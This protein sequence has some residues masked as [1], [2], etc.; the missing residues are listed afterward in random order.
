VKE[1]DKYLVLK[2][3]GRVAVAM[4]GGVDSSTAAAILKNDG[5][6]VI[7]LTMHLWDQKLDDP[8]EMGRCCSPEDIRDARR[9]ADQIGIPHY[10]INLRKA[11]EEEVV[12][13]FI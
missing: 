9:V 4:S 1:K 2:E 10:V 13:D 3:K 7:G 6:E 5:Y 8:E 12:H 11:F